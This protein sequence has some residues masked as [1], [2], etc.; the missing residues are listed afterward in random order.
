MTAKE[1]TEKIE[2][3]DCIFENNNTEVTV[4]RIED[5]IHNV[6]RSSDK[7]DEQIFVDAVDKLICRLNNIT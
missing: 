5:Y 6:N 4:K 1:E 2:N 3:Y 7:F